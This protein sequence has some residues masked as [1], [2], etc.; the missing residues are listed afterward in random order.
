[1]INEKQFQ[2]SHHHF[3]AYSIYFMH[4][5]KLIWYSFRLLRCLIERLWQQLNRT[6][7]CWIVPVELISPLNYSMRPHVIHR[8]SSI[9]VNNDVPNS[10]RHS[11]E[12]DT[13]IISTHHLID[14]NTVD[15]QCCF[16][17]TLTTNFRWIIFEFVNSIGM[18][19]LMFFKE[20]K[21]W[22]NIVVT[23]NENSFFFLLSNIFSS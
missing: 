22:A 2:K 17:S 4:I 7:L 16:S 12:I 9:N 1:M 6:W 20:F 15:Q 19:T 10:N 11:S 14:N 3:H 23:T 21:L 18:Q 13:N 5:S 8:C